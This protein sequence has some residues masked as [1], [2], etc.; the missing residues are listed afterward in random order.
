MNRKP[1]DEAA[2]EIRFGVELETI[3]P[4]S[5]GI[6]IGPYHGGRLVRGGIEFG[7]GLAIWP[8]EFGGKHW[9]ADCDGSIQSKAGFRP[10]EFVSPVLHGVEG[11]EAL[12]KF[13]VFANRLGAL[14]NHSCG[15]HITVGV[16][17]VIGSADPERVARFVRRLT[18]VT[19][20]HAWGLFGQT[21]TNRH[22]NNFCSRFPQ[23][24]GMATNEMLLCDLG[25]DLQKR[26]KL[27][28]SVGRGAVSFLKSFQPDM[29]KSAVEFRVF[30]GTQNENKILHHLATVLGLCRRAATTRLVPP[31]IP[32]KRTVAVSAPEAITVLW[33][34][35]GWI[36]DSAGVDVAF[37]QFGALHSSFE[38]YKGAA[39][40]MAEKFE[41]RFPAAKL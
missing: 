5:S 22:K 27:A 37:G 35:L 41:K 21:G 14:V 2:A 26:N 12:R 19:N 11:V 8:P 16:P 24:A 23:H 36:E 28:T 17:S 32:T 31:F 38:A 33:H 4:D 7:T 30:A 29:T 25:N 6:E 20:Q 15:C 9:R 40:M 3:V 1:A 13:I 39:M 18:R 34:Y 10:C